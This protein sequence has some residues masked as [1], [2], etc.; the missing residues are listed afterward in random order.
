MTA[1]NPAFELLRSQSIESLQ[2]TVEE[3]RHIKTGAQH[4][5]IDADNNENVFLVALR[6]VPEDS[7]GVAHILEHTALCG[8]AKYPVRD[9]FFM[10][11]RRSL[12][13]FMN[14]MTSSDWT[15]YPFASQN[16]KDFNNL[17]DVYLDAVFFS[18]LDPLDFA[19]EG[20]RLEFAEPDNTESELV[21]KGV[22]FNEM[23]GAMSSVTS[24]LWQ[25]VCKY[26][27]PTNTY[28]FNSGGD[29]ECITDLSYEQLKHF[30]ETHYHPSNAVFLTYGDISAAEHQA[31]F[32]A[33]ALSHFEPLEE[34]IAVED[35]KRYLAPV[36]VEEAYPLTDATSTDG[37]THVVLAWLLGKS[38]NLQQSLEAQL[39]SSILLDNSASPLQHALETT[40]LGSAPSPL[41]GLDDSQ[42]ELSFMCG[43]EGSDVAKA[44]QVEAMVLEVI[45]RVANEGVPYD[46]LKAALQQLELNQREV[47]GDSYPYGLQ[48]IMTTLTSVTH[49]GDPIALLN[50]DPAL[51]KLHADIKDPEFIK[52]LARQLLLDNQH[53]VRL[54]LRPD[55]ELAQRR[56]AAE[57]ARL[58]A[59]KAQLTAADKDAIAA[60]A[61]ALQARQ[62][63]QD[64]DAVLPKVGLD[65]IPPQM[66]YTA[67][68]SVKELPTRLTN[69]GAGTN[70]LV[71]QQIILELP[72]LEPEQL[73][74]LSYYGMFLTEL[75][76]G[77]KSYLDVQRWQAQV[78]GSIS[79]YA[80]IR[81]ASDD[82]QQVKANLTLSAKA[83][84]PQQAALCELMWSTLNDVRFDEHTRLQELV[85]QI[86]A[87][88]EQSVTGNGH[89]LAMSAASAGMSPAAKI[90]H[91]LFGLGGIQAIKK[92]DVELK[93]P[94]QLRAF[95]EGLQRLHQQVLQ[96]TRQ[97]LLVC[98]PDDIEEFQQNIAQAWPTAVATTAKPFSLEPVR[99]QLS[100]AWIANTQVNFCAKAY[101]TVPVEHP[102]AAALT[103]LGGFLRNGYLHRVIREQ[104]GAYGGG[105]SQDSGIAAF[106][107]YSYRDPRLSETL[108]DFD[109]SIQWLLSKEH[110][111]QP[112]EEAILGVISSLDKPS[113]PA[114]EAKQTFHAELF[115]RS[116]EKRELFRKQI[117]EVT[118]ADL[119]RVA[120]TYLRPELASV[121]VVTGSANTALTRDLGMENINL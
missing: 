7:T 72:Q 115:G 70:G 114:G 24:Q 51:E 22:V 74:T 92:L 102:D 86:R 59:I 90:S 27:F 58:A 50:L 111:Y 63:Q 61:K 66:H 20:H 39:L 62:L 82:V 81:G 76:V 45:E 119:K 11:I 25:T 88:R 35:E 21:Y 44:D 116:R 96:C 107:M 80:T 109:E 65:D 56:V 93:D 41:C 112:L 91:Q 43:L 120:E 110:E 40:D 15:A 6:T 49:R 68:H 30:Y 17:L 118:V 9:P 52:R 106:R 14:A 57:A 73:E 34:F 113:S 64:D 94:Q 60:Q 75:G 101:P 23:K 46:E 117:L 89:G 84:K 97:Y 98:E 2:V 18:R 79:A 77:D 85:A 36:R 78:A 37:K 103:V 99:E 47:G 108:K 100:Q 13:T 67:H 5:H 83:L 55:T 10:M 69:Y 38:T 104:G 42:K 87:R 29:P 71:Y 1:A 28:H 48:I 95:G 4:I 8:S 16:R 19:Q 33:Q 12:N 32:E 105:A 54:T 121:A 31:K 53:R 26:L 3:Y